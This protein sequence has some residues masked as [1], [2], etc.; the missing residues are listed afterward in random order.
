MTYAL[1][2]LKNHLPHGITEWRP[3]YY[4]CKIS[5]I[6]TLMHC[7]ILEVLSKF[8][9]ENLTLKKNKKQK[10][11]KPQK[12]KSWGCRYRRR[13]ERGQGVKGVKGVKGDQSQWA[14]GK[15]ASG[16]VSLRASEHPAQAGWNKQR[17]KALGSVHPYKIKPAWLMKI[18][19]IQDVWECN[20]SAHLAVFM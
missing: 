4:M 5:V 6:F 10:N 15:R 11:R 16:Q 19:S 9:A 18:E 1:K 2:F 20:C 3:F 13:R 8:A 12:I 14:A 17:A 7:F